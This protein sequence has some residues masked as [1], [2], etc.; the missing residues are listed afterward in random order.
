MKI[1]IEFLI[2]KQNAMGETLVACLK[3]NVELDKETVIEML[4]AIPV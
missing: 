4:T 2:S 3:I 1:E